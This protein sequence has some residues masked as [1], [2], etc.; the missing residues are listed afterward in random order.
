MVKVFTRS[1]IFPMHFHSLFPMHRLYNPVILSPSYLGIT[2]EVSSLSL[3]VVFLPLCLPRKMPVLIVIILI[4]VCF[5]KALFQRGEIVH[6]PVQECAGVFALP[7][8]NNKSKI[9]LITFS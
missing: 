2:D 9:N 3:S 6:C 1:K 4:I 8:Q 7:P 5:L